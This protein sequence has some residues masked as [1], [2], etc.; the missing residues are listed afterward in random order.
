MK[1][2]TIELTTQCHKKCEYCSSNSD[3]EKYTEL[4]LEKVKD[5]MEQNKDRDIISISG[6]EPLLHPDIGEILLLAHEKFEKVEVYTNLISNI[7]FNSDVLP[8]GIETHSNTIIRPGATIA[9]AD[10]L[11]LLELKHHGRAKEIKE[12]NYS[13]SG[14]NCDECGH[15]VVQADGK[16]VRPCAKKYEKRKVNVCGS[17]HMLKGECVCQ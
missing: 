8:D 15:V 3:F 12:V 10:N 11:R 5:I 7:R 13:I 6:G 2:L 17:T 9:P 1:E 4:S 14:C 16:Q